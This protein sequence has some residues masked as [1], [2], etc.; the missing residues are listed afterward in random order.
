MPC[1]MLETMPACDQLG[2]LIKKHGCR[3]ADVGGRNRHPE[4]LML[5]A[6]HHRGRVPMPTL[7]LLRL[8]QSPALPF[9]CYRCPW[10][11]RCR[12]VCCLNMPLATSFASKKQFVDVLRGLELRIIE[13]HHA[14]KERVEE[15]FLC[16]TA[17][18][19]MTARRLSKGS[20]TCCAFVLRRPILGRER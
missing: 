19:G 2:E 16:G 17:G 15:A 12:S 1:D 10:W 9:L 8:A 11:E 4:G 13:D 6:C 3:L 20:S 5:A 14:F 18:I 7:A